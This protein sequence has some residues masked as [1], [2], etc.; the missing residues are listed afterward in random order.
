MTA[1][2]T[3]GII[4]DRDYSEQFTNITLSLKKSTF[5]KT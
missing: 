1:T 2:D 5:L 4:K 3:D